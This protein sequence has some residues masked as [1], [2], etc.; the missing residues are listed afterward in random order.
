M[1]DQEHREVACGLALTQDL[2]DLRLDGHIERRGRLVGDQQ[3]RVRLASAMAIIA[4][5]AMPPESMNG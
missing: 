1:R 5:C 2:D 3:R 4:R